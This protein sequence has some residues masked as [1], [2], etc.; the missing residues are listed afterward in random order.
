MNE[1][2][3]V[4]G[5]GYVGLPL[6][7]GLKFAGHNV[8]GFDISVSRVDEL[9]KCYDK[10]LETPSSDLKKAFD[11]GFVITNNSKQI[12]EC[13]V[14]IITVP[15]PVKE[16]YKPDLSICL[17]V[18]ELLS[19]ILSQNDLV[20]WE[21]TVS[22]GATREVFMP[23]LTESNNLEMSGSL[24]VGYSPERI[25]P[26]D[27]DHNIHNTTKVISGC[28]PSCIQ[29]I[30]KIYSSICQNIHV[31][32][33]IE[34]A[35]SCKL[36]E[37]IQRDVNIALMNEFFQIMN[38]LQIDM[39][40]VLSAAQTKWNFLNFYPGLVGGHCISI[41]P[42]YLIDKAK[43]LSLD[44]SL[45]STARE[46]NE[47]MIDYHYQKITECLIRNEVI[48][49]KV[50]AL[51]GTFKPDCSDIRNSKPL[52]IYNKLIKL[53][54]SVELFDPYIESL[55]NSEIRI[56]NELSNTNYDLVIFGVPHRELLKSQ[57]IKQF[58][59]CAFYEL[60]SF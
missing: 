19:P 17:N 41:D 30:K 1:K 14:Y 56:V 38:H 33:N 3:C 5:L 9:K 2:I 22:P 53:N 47:Y 6:A 28:C 43:S 58:K 11:K 29:R 26:G 52:E 35:E 34:V 31:A 60:Q 15:T 4:I 39:R 57:Y 42:H 40:S 55:P 36:L 20:I 13:N 16:K 44:T 27:T 7:I 12:T 51:G 10:N 59:E 25:N 50:L 48:H 8:T 24:C 49:R 54:Y 46:I 21:S 23:A 18:A 32:E 45:I 37:N